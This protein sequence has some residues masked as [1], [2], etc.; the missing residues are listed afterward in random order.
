[1]RSTD[2]KP[3]RVCIR[4]TSAQITDLRKQARGAGKSV[5]ELIRLRATYQPVVSSTDAI[6][7][8][9][10]DQLGRM[11]KLLYPKGK[12]WAT[13]EDRRKW[14]RLVEDLQHTVAML[15]RAR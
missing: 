13:A 12:G 15:R 11:L 8:Q 14:W 4:F 1:M 7:A 6:T 10:I 5:S 9:R 3:H 2:R